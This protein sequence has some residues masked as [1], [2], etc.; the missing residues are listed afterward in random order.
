[1]LSHVSEVRIRRMPLGGD[2]RVC[3]AYSETDDE[4]ENIVKDALE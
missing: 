4:M 2:A 1:M 3:V